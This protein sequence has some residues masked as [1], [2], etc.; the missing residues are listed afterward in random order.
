MMNQQQL[1]G[2]WNELRGRLRERWGQL[3]EDDVQE[4]SGDVDQLVGLIQ[5]KTG[6]S[7]EQIEAQLDALTEKSSRG[8]ARAGEAIQEYSRQSAEAYNRMAGNLQAGYADAEEMIRRNPAESIA[9]AFGT[10]LVAGVIIG[11]VA[12]R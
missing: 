10:G 9:V 5:Q 3:T 6:E 1:R 4:F 8:A 12:R 11:L 2:N 7:R